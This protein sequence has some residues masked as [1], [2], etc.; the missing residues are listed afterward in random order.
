M[1]L[2]SSCTENKGNGNRVGTIVKFSKSGVL[3][4]SWEGHLNLTQTGM[5]SAGGFDFSI[6]NDNEDQKIIS[7]LDSALNGGWHVELK[8]HEVFGFNWF[9]NR[10]STDYFVTECKVLNRNTGVGFGQN[11]Q[12]QPIQ[13]SNSDNYVRVPVKPGQGIDSI[14]VIYR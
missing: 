10:G 14:I 4:K 13:N 2:L 11:G 3:W 5:N 1:A 7:T 6:D 9:S 8:Y 12:S